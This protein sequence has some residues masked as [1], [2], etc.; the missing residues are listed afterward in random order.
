M[1]P[2]VLAGTALSLRS[3][4]SCS[5]DLGKAESSVVFTDFPSLCL[6]EIELKLTELVDLSDVNLCDTSLWKLEGRGRLFGGLIL[7]LAGC[8]S[9][10]KT[11][12]NSFNE[13]IEK[14]YNSV[15]NGLISR[16]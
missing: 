3:A 4:E 13:A 14:H 15:L 16:I 5:S 7:A 10:N 12:T 6:A 9:P 1:V 11:K 8:I 2:V